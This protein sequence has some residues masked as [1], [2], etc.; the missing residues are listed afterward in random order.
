MRAIWGANT[1][2]LEWYSDNTLLDVQQSADTCLYDGAITLPSTNPTKTGY[3]FG[4]WQVKMP[5]QMC[6]EGLNS[7]SDGNLASAHTWRNNSDFCSSVNPYGMGAQGECTANSIALNEWTTRF[8]YGIVKGTAS[9][10]STAPS[11]WDTI[12]SGIEN[13]TI[14]YEQAFTMLWGVNGSGIKAS[15][16]FNQSSIGQYCWCRGTGY[17]PESNEETC[18]TSSYFWVFNTDVETTDDCA[19]YCASYCAGSM[20]RDQIFRQAIFNQN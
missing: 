16:T 8:S 3:T 11:N 13:N 15:D 2:N 18:E 10:N 12:I 4:G 6:F 19:S 14:T 20:M 9:C 5:I 7:S 1:I 17:T